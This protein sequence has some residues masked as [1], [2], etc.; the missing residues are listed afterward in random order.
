MQ[1]HA[2]TK[3]MGTFVKKHFWYILGGFVVLILIILQLTLAPLLKSSPLPDPN[4]DIPFSY[5]LNQPDRVIRLTNK[6]E[7]ISGLSISSTGYWLA[8]QDEEGKIFAFGPDQL[9]VEKFSYTKPGDFEGVAATPKHL[10]T[11]RSDGTIYRIKHPGDPEKQKVK[12]YETHLSSKNDTEGLCFDS[13]NNRLLVACKGSPG[14][15]SSLK[16]KRAIYAFDLEEKELSDDPVFTISLKKIQ[17]VTKN[18]KA[19]FRPS[20]IAI[21]PVTKEIYIIATVGKLL[22]VLH[23]DGKFKQAKHL[24]HDHFI[25]PEGIA[26]LENGDLLIAN[27]A[28]YKGSS[29]TILRFNTA[30]PSP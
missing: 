18:S 4:P 15:S 29:P 17:S 21:H 3:V 19:E 27:E 14:G 26:F 5:N 9:K 8:V 28:K 2:G 6:L 7:E 16:G 30:K 23:P 12:K 20:G 25:Q 22:V 10:Y 24:D 1:E 11:L 13:T